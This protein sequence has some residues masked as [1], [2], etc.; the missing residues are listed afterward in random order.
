MHALKIKEVDTRIESEI[1]GLR[2]SIQSA[3]FNV[4]QVRFS[5]P[6]IS[7]TSSAVR[8]DICV[9]LQLLFSCAARLVP[10]RCRNGCWRPALGLSQNVPLDLVFFSQSLLLT[11]PNGTTCG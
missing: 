8:A 3:K 2:T 5:S 6:L 9:L 4:L 7:H 11:N 10:G 1:A